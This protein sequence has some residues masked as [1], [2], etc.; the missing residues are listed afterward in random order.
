MGVLKKAGNAVI[1]AVANVLF[2]IVGFIMSIIWRVR[3]V[4]TDPTTVDAMK[5]GAV[6]IADHKSHM[7]GFFVPVMLFPVRIHVL[8]TRKWYNKRWLKPIFRHL[9]YIPI[10]LDAPDASWLPTA[11]EALKR[12]RCVMI[13]PEGKLEREGREKFLSGF[14]LPVKHLGV[15]VVPMTIKGNYVPFMRHTLLVG[16]PLTPDLNTGGRLSAV[17]NNAARECEREV[18]ALADME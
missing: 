9:P 7:D 12:G 10:N 11:E 1:D 18:F 2:Y 17:L 4:Y 5:K 3:L 15:P 8:I 16:S 14:L 13:F 6:L